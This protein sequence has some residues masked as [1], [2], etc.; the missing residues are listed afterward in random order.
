MLTQHS[1]LL[2]TVCVT[3]S[4]QDGVVRVLASKVYTSAPLGLSVS[5]CVELIQRS[6]STSMLAIIFLS[7]VCSSYR[8]LA[9]LETMSACLCRLLLHVHA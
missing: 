4:H 3:S 2:S 7:H 9:A 5:F 8:R 1:L 6:V